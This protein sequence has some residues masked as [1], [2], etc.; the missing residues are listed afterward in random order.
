MEVQVKITEILEPQSFLGKDG[1][2]TYT[3]YSFVGTTFG[4]YPRSIYFQT[5]GQDK[6]QQMNIQLGGIYTISFDIE[7][8]KYNDKYF[9]SINAWKAVRENE[10][11]IENQQQANPYQQQ[12]SQQ[13]VYG[14]G[15]APAP[16]PM[17]Q[18]QSDNGPLPF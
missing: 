6:Y 17:P 16:A 10:Q 2:T 5:L 12:Q 13:P 7:S 8:R 14:N 11:S 4:D 15:Y 1:I 9:S 18:Q 3:R